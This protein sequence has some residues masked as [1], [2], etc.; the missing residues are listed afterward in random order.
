MA[1][2]PIVL[3]PLDGSDVSERVLPYAAEFAARAGGRLHLLSVFEGIEFELRALQSAETIDRVRAECL[4]FY[5]EYLAAAK[6][7][8]QGVEVETQ[9]AE[10]HPVDVIADVAD[11]LKPYIV[12]MSTHG[13]SGLGRALMGSVADK[14]TRSAKYPTLLVRNE[15]EGRPAAYTVGKIMLPLDGSE[16]SEG[17]IPMTGTVAQHHNATVELVRVVPFASAGVYAPGFAG[18][19]YAGTIDEVERSLEQAAEAYLQ[20]KMPLVTGAPSVRAFVLRGSPFQA[21]S[22]FAQEREA[23]LVVMSSHGRSGLR[24]LA[25]GSVATSVIQD[26]GVPVLL[27]PSGE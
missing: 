7:K 4:G 11:E 15:K 8:V 22:D 17:A 14:V 3:V 18:A 9:V 1:N 27:V 12:A 16:L 20:Q 25:L 2:Q 19:A 23:D 5:E 13:R 26:S 24:R 21:I 10:G 6:A